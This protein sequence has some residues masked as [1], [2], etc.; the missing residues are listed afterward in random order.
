MRFRRNVS[1]PQELPFLP[2][3]SSELHDMKRT[4]ACDEL[5]ADDTHA[6]IWEDPA[7]MVP[8]DI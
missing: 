6:G 3:G 5:A 2:Q 4:A 1:D 7:S 8:Y